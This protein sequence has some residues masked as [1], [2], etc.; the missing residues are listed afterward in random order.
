M[1]LATN[2]KQM[3]VFAIVVAVT[4]AILQGFQN[5]GTLTG[6]ANTAI[7]TFISAID[8]FATWAA[9]I[10]LGIVG[11]FLLRYMSQKAQVQL[12]VTGIGTLSTNTKAVGTFAIVVAVTLAILQGFQSSGALGAGAGVNDTPTSAYAAVTTFVNAIDDFATWA[13]VIV[14]GIVGFFLLRYMSQKA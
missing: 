10:V 8:D 9:V 6:N 12:K 13:A 1:Q 2:A 4:L 7:T 3:G 5:S 11:F 14:L